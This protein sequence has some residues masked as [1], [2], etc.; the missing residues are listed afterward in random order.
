MYD[1]LLQIGFSPIGEMLLANYTKSIK[2]PIPPQEGL[3]LNGEAHPVKRGHYL[4]ITKVA[5]DGNGCLIGYC[6]A[7]DARDLGDE[8][9]E[10]AFRVFGWAPVSSTPTV[11][12]MIPTA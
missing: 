5:V 8:S 11:K 6:G 10:P 3:I 12:P 7:Y 2:L 9:E 4:A 1:V